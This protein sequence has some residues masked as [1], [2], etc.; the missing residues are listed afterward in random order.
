MAK[1]LVIDDEKNLRRILKDYLENEGNEVLT[2]AGGEEG[3]DMALETL[4]LDL[5]LLDIRMPGMDGFEVMEELAGKIQVPVIFLTALGDNFNEIKGLDLG[6]DDY[7][8]KPFNY[9]V[10]MARINAILRK[11]QKK[12]C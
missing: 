8:S 5:I 6:A 9:K 7:I 3:I 10:L 4:N 11:N 1:I 12:K 2:A